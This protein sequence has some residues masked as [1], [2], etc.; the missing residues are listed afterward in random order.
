MQFGPNQILTVNGRWLQFSIQYFLYYNSIPMYL[1]TIGLLSRIDE[2]RLNLTLDG[3]LSQ[4]SILISFYYY[5]IPMY[6]DT[7][8][9]LWVR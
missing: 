3:R 5:L 7:I 6:L 4:F 2:D 9:L 1:S 8:G